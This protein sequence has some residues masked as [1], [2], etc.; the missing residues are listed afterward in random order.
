MMKLYREILSAI[1]ASLL[2]V[3]LSACEKEGTAEQ[4]GEAIDEAAS[5]VAEEA[6]EATEAIQEKMDEK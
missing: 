3:G 5:D 1:L 6:K 2:V 4:A